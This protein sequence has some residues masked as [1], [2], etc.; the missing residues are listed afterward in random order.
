VAIL[1]C[2]PPIDRATAKLDRTLYEAPEQLPLAIRMA[3]DAPRSSD[4]ANCLEGKRLEK[5]RC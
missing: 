2:G 5:T 1:R 4:R 3:K